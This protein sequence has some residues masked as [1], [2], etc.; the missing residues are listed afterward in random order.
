MGETSVGMVQTGG[1]DVSLLIAA[2]AVLACVNMQGDV[3]RDM[4]SVFVDFGCAGVEV[5]VEHLF[6]FIKVLFI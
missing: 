3:D 2:V 6:K 1:P 4:R 5:I